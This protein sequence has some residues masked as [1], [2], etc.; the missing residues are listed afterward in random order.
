MTPVRF[1][2]KDRLVVTAATIAGLMLQELCVIC[3]TLVAFCPVAFPVEFFA[4]QEF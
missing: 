2:E 3:E 1:L 4:N